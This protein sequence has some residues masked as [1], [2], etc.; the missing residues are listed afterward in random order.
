MNTIANA[1]NKAQAKHETAAEIQERTTKHHN[2]VV[3]ENGQNEEMAVTEANH[4]P[5]ASTRDISF[6]FDE[7]GNVT[8]D[9]F[10]TGIAE[11]SPRF[12][13]TLQENVDRTFWSTFTDL[14]RIANLITLEYGVIPQYDQ[15]GRAFQAAQMPEAFAFDKDIMAPSQ[16]NETEGV[17]Q[18]MSWQEIRQKQTEGLKPMSGAQHT[19]Y[20]E[21]CE[22]VLAGISY[23]HVMRDL[24]Y[25]SQHT[26]E[27]VWAAAKESEVKRQKAY[28]ERQELEGFRNKE[29]NTAALAEVTKEG[30]ALDL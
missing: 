22:R 15:L 28:Q 13:D 9:S 23:L 14:F 21:T 16:A 27:D 29:R 6:T 18:P 17:L 3:V 4:R 5:V 24:G 25:H 30:G 19:F 8:A 1:M 2:N 11:I 7:E 10:Q 26:R 12:A 20:I